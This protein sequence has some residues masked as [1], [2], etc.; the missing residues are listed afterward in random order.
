MRPFFLSFAN[1]LNMKKCEQAG[2]YKLDSSFLLAV[3]HDARI[4]LSHLLI[5][6]SRNSIKKFGF[7]VT[8]TKQ[9]V[10]KK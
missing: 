4:H 5:V 1:I 9:N 7:Y 2:F 3:V 8:H 6:D 10:Y